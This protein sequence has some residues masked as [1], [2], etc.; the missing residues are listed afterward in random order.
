MSLRLEGRRCRTLS[1]R[2]EPSP[3]RRDNAEGRM[4][5]DDQLLV[6]LSRQLVGF[7]YE[8][9]GA[10]IG[11]REFRALAFVGQKRSCTVGELAADQGLPSATATRLCDQLEGRKWLRRSPSPEDRRS[12]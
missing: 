4:S 8:S 5:Q 1:L 10:D 3:Y 9:V 7:A 12:V 2:D 6:E 11:L